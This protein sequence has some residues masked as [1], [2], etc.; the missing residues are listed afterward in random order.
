[1]MNL[2]KSQVNI[3]IDVLRYPKEFFKRITKEKGFKK[4]LKFLFFITLINSIFMHLFILLVN[5][6]VTSN[7][8][9]QGGIVLISLL[10]SLL[11]YVVAGFLVTAGMSLIVHLYSKLFKGKGKLYQSFQLFIYASTPTILFGWIPYVSLLT[12]I[13]MIYLLYLGGM[14]LHGF[15]NRRSMIAFVIIPMILVIATFLLPQR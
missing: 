15:T 3:V 14:I 7:L 8:Q 12:T 6:T 4:S 11:M 2:L 5:A 13:Y 9:T 10:I 1:M